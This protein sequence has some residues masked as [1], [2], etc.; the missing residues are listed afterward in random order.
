MADKAEKKTCFVVSPIGAAGSTER[1][2]ADWLLEGIIKPVFDANYPDFDVVRADKMPAPGMIDS[3]I[4]E[5]LLDADLVIADITTLNPNVFYEIGIRHMAQKPVVHMVLE[6]AP[7]PFDIKIFKHIPFSVKTPQ[8][9][10]F[11]ME[12]LKDA[13]DAVFH[14]DFKVDNPVT[15]TRARAELEVAGTPTE[16]ILLGELDSIN[17]RLQ[18]MEYAVAGMPLGGGPLDSDHYHFV[19][20]MLKQGHDRLHVKARNED[21]DVDV[22]SLLRP[23]VSR[24]QYA[25]IH[26]LSRNEAFISIPKGGASD[27]LVLSIKRM[28]GDQYEV[29]S[30]DHDIFG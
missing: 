1:I 4:I 2:H 3:Q 8:G 13:L 19:N 23:I 27:K 15:R 26:P 30:I 5:H 22:Q 9:L 14:P 10:V 24:M 6:D 11:A 21:P 20:E 29:K 28:I 12:A 18:V 16:K 17:S 7:I 25:E